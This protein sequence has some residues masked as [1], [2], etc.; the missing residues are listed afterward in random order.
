MIARWVTPRNTGPLSLQSLCA[1][2][3][4]CCLGWMRSTIR[5]SFNI[6][7][8]GFVVLL[9]L[10]DCSCIGSMAMPRV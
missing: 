9:I 6:Y 10:L 8:I 4:Q 5:S 2:N 1:R 7:P 3:P